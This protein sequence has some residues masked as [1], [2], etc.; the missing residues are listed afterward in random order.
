MWLLK[1][2]KTILTLGLSTTVVTASFFLSLN[3]W[4]HF[5]D[6]E[7][8]SSLLSPM[9]MR[10]MLG[11][12]LLALALSLFLGLISHALLWAAKLRSCPYYLLAG[13]LGGCA[14][15]LLFG[16]KNIGFLIL[17]LCAVGIALIFWLVR[18]PDRDEVLTR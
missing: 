8:W 2:L 13:C 4:D 18:R 11:I 9:N 1:I 6:N 10:F 5:H 12:W 3:L 16:L 7:T 15:S 17:V 14:I